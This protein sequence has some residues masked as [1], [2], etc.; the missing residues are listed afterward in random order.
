MNVP[1]T[2]VVVRTSAVIQ[3]AAITASVKL[4][5]CWREMAEDV[6]VT[7]LSAY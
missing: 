3:L 6:K 7:E 5:S 1:W 2:M 4:A